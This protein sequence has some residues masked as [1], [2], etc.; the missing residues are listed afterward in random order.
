ME[1]INH[2][3]FECCGANAAGNGGSKCGGSPN[4]CG[5]KGGMLSCGGGVLHSLACFSGVSFGLW[6]LRLF[7]LLS[8]LFW[9]SDRSR[10]HWL[11]SSK[12]LLLYEC[13]FFISAVIPLPLKIWFKRIG[14][15]D[16]ID[17]VGREALLNSDARSNLAEWLWDFF[18]ETNYYNF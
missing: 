16:N 12:A 9:S 3:L 4:A 18:S 14:G 5:M 2:L 1:I 10:A 17:V 13:A 7:L 8:W 6:L 15:G 11:D